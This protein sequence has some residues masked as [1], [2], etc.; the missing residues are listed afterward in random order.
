MD[1]IVVAKLHATPGFSKASLL[2][3]WI[4]LYAPSPDRDGCLTYF[5]FKS[6]STSQPTIPSVRL[7]NCKGQEGTTCN[8]CN[9]QRS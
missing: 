6:I 4:R 2:T 9:G 3:P 7:Q 8:I 5:G 1:R